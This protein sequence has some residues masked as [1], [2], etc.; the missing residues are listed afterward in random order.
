MTR[1]TNL[2]NLNLIGAQ[3]PRLFTCICLVLFG[4]AS[5]LS[6]A[7]EI[8]FEQQAGDVA[9]YEFAEISIHVSGS[10]IGN[11]FTD[12]EVSGRFGKADTSE[13]VQVEGFCDSSDGSVFRIRFMPVAPGNYSYSVIYRQGGVEKAHEGTFRAIDKHKSGPIRVDPKYPWHFLWEGTGEHYFFNGTTA[14]WL[15][16]WRDDRVIRF[17]IERL[18]RL[19][20]NRIRVLLAGN[21]DIFWGEKVM[22]GENFTMALRPWVAKTP[23]SFD[24]PGI[25]FTRFNVAYWQKWERMLRFAR[26]RDMIISV[27][28]DI[29]T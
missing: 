17:S 2:Y 29:S 28:L 1:S 13:R 8:S 14:F 5:D 18:Q 10:D 20:I 26:D 15:M 27:I 23:E 11:P 4:I 22:T 19:K 16:G 7:P 21:A 24:N 25:D 6:A 12:G 9:T 3:M